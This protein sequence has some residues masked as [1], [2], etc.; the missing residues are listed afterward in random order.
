MRKH[1]YYKYQI[2]MLSVYP[3]APHLFS[4]ITTTTTKTVLNKYFSNAILN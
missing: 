4:T 1:K 3:L 2:L